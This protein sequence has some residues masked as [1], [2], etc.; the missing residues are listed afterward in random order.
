MPKGSGAVTDILFQGMGVSTTKGHTEGSSLEAPK[1]L[2]GVRVY[3]A[4]R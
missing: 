2:E 3:G 1:G 4:T